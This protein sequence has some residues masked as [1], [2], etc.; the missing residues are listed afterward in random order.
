[1]DR[2]PLVKGDDTREVSRGVNFPERLKSQLCE[3]VGRNWS[4]RFSLGNLWRHGGWRC[5]LSP[6]KAPQPASRTGLRWPFSR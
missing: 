1:M 4:L 3:R 6:P 5:N 2:A